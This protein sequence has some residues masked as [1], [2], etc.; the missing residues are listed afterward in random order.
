[1][2]PASC[3]EKIGFH[4]VHRTLAS[5]RP[6]RPVSGSSEDAGVGLRSDAGRVRLVPL[7]WQHTEVTVSDRMLGESGQA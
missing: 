3:I 7:T 2:P 1:M 6:V 4:I 5:T